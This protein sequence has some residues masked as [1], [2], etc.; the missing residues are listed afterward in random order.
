MDSLAAMLV[1]VLASSGQ[2][3]LTIEL[4]RATEMSGA[5]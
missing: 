5:A 1:G 2:A 3:N 4:I